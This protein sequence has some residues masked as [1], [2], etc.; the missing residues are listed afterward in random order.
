MLKT[1]AVLATLLLSACTGLK[2]QRDQNLGGAG[3]SENMLPGPG[4]DAGS[5]DPAGS[6][7][8]SAP[9][10]AG[11]GA[12]SGGERSPSA[13]KGG[14]GAGGSAGK[15]A[16][17]SGSGGSTGGAGAGGT[18]T[19][20][21]AG[22]GGTGGT[23]GSG[24]A[25]H[26]P[27]AG[28]GGSGPH[29][30]DE[31][32][33]GDVRCGS[34]TQTQS[35]VLTD[36]CY[37]WGALKA[38]QTS[39]QHCTGQAP[40]AE[41]TCMAPPTACET[42]AGSYCRSTSS[43]GTCVADAASCI[44]EQAPVAC[45]S[46]MPCSGELPAAS[47]SCAAP[48]TE[49]A[50][51]S[52]DVCRSA[53]AVVSCERNASGCLAI[54][55]T[56]SCTAGKPCTGA[57]GEADC[58]CPAAP[59][60]CLDATSG[61]VCQ[62]DTSY[63]ACSTSSEGCVTSAAKSC[64][65]GKP[66]RGAAGSAAC[67]CIDKPSA[68]DCPSGSDQGSRCVGSVLYTCGSNSDGCATLKKTSCPSG[69]AC[70]DNYPS[71]RCI[72][73]VVMGACTGKPK[74]SCWIGAESTNDTAGYTGYAKAQS[75][76]APDTTISRVDIYVP[77]AIAKPWELRVVSG[78]PQKDPAIDRGVVLASDLDAKTL[79]TAKV[80]SSAAGW[81]TLNF[82]PAISVQTNATYYVFVAGDP[83]A[84]PGTGPRNW[85]QSTPGDQPGPYAAG[86]AWVLVYDWTDN[87][88]YNDTMQK[89]SDYAFRV[90]P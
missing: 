34:E 9:N 46:G 55:T 51:V 33:A 89:H 39:H 73:M 58:R 37:A 40:H 50:G 13:G 80:N 44:Y 88:N 36:G 79:G 31:C 48:P 27:E 62:S 81:V 54:T 68:S 15:P 72:D 21:P 42:G 17:V 8:K 57:P 49:C 6:G 38:C 11:A 67:T 85:S 5:T 16:A 28:S 63:V 83:S 86:T 66:C 45:P 1:A 69:G 43:V 52:G 18:S 78:L 87:N 22:T 47:C 82:S 71:A 60:A 65:A 25:G 23:G 61:N 35:C 7:G 77:Q 32:S 76:A 3:T 2:D 20:A 64:S 4:V 30:S 26:E 53:Q 56:K 90:W 10:E 29:C 19:P 70:V 24:E 12:G 59:A 74:G 75:F 41:C 14:A 84:D